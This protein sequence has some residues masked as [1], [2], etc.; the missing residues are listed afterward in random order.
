M[1]S[2]KPHKQLILFHENV[3][4]LSVVRMNLI[5]QRGRRLFDVYNIHNTKDLASAS[6]SCVGNNWMEITGYKTKST[7]MIS[8]VIS[9][10]M[11]PVLTFGERFIF[12]VTQISIGI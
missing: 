8:L 3:S 7:W 5:I 6:I 10:K 1:L 11:S 9:V 4:F 12:D 2:L